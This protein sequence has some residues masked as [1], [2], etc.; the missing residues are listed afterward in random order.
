M[1]RADFL[2]L[3]GAADGAADY[4][5]LACL[6]RSGYGIA[7][8][9]N[10]MLNNDLQQSVVL[11]NARLVDLHSPRRTAS[12]PTI[13][14]FSEFIEEIVLRHYMG[15]QSPARDDE[16]GHSIPLAAIGMEEIAVAYPVAHIGRMMQAL[17]EPAAVTANGDGNHDATESS[18]GRRVPSF[19][20]FE[21]RRLVLKVL[22]T[23]LW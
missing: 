19:L 8:H 4:V 12:G 6:L 9:Y 1:N 13:S 20:D 17:S 5:P 21:N 22:R 16:Y 10:A 14:D 15:E 23:K 11:V 18:D 7:G 2:K 3:I